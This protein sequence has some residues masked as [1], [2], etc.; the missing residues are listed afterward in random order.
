M[1]AIQQLVFGPRTRE[2]STTAW[3]VGLPDGKP[4]DV[5]FPS[6]HLMVKGGKLYVLTKSNS[7]YMRKLFITLENKLQ[8]ILMPKV[9]VKDEEAL[10]AMLKMYIIDD[11]G[12]VIFRF[13]VANIEQFEPAGDS[14]LEPDVN[15]SLKLT[16]DAVNVTKAKVYVYWNIAAATKLPQ[17]DTDDETTDEDARVELVRD[18][19]EPDTD[20]IGGIRHGIEIA[21]ESEAESL[22]TLQKG[23]QKLEE[24]IQSI[25]EFYRSESATFTLEN[26]N[27]VNACLEK[28]RETRQKLASGM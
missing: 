23:M 14:A 10:R 4:L 6:A 16:I 9:K 26:L 11:N 13:N 8:D 24:I 27:H 22:V 20:D 25:K 15:Y 5:E 19:P 17:F 1:E 12:D 7:K 2:D 28:F 3:H 21:I 18:D